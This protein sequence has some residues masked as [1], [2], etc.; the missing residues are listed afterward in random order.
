M[1]T[2][3]NFIK[4]E[5]YYRGAPTPEF[6]KGNWNGVWISTA[7][8]V[9]QQYGTLWS[10]ETTEPL[11]LLNNELNIARIFEQ[12]FIK[13]YPELEDEVNQDGDF[14]ELWLFPPD[15]FIKILEDKGYDGFINGLDTLLFNSS[16]HKIKLIQ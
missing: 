10:Y 3:I 13:K 8:W 16:T 1:K 14:S 7:K 15:K 6:K 2:F 5:I 4:E 9:A 12:D 11:N